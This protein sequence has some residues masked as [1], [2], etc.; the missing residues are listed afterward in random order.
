VEWF[1]IV[2]ISLN[3]SIACISHSGSI[4]EIQENVENVNFNNAEKNT[5]VVE[6][7][8]SIENGISTA[9]WNADQSVLLIVTNNN[10]IISMTS[11]WEVLNE[12]QISQRLTFSDSFLSWCGNGDMFS[13][14]YV[15]AEDGL[16]KVK[17][18]NKE[19]DELSIA[20]NVA[21][22]AASIVKN[23]GSVACF[24]TNGNYF[25]TSLI[26]SKNK[27]QVAFK[28]TFIYYFFVS[29]F[30]FLIP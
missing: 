13:I 5:R 28:K 11:S 10:T 22:G 12:I 1:S 18:Y 24:A 21:D 4:A 6:Q 14:L 7:V 16:K 30:Y 27:L 23:I 15:D 8:G 25:A 26:K 2:R 17:I 19:L 20:R 3:D 29:L 9:S